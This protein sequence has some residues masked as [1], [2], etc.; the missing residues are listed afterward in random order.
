[1]KK[2]EGK[3]K[4]ALIV[5]GILIIS[6]INARAGTGF[7]VIEILEKYSEDGSSG[8]YFPEG[9]IGSALAV[10]TG[11]PLVY[12]VFFSQRY[13]SEGTVSLWFKITRT[14]HYDAQNLLSITDIGSISFYT[15]DGKS[16]TFNFPGGQ[17]VVSNDFC[18]SFHHLLF[19]WNSKNEA[20][21]IDG[22][23]VYE[24]KYTVNQIPLRD[25]SEALLTIH[26]A[27]VSLVDEIIILDRYTPEENLSIFSKNKVPW[28]VD[29]NTVFYAGFD[30][31][32]RAKGVIKQGDILRIAAYIGRVDATF[33]KGEVP[34][35]T[36]HILNTTGQNQNVVL[37]GMIKDIN[38]NIIM[39]KILSV[40]VPALDIMDVRFRMDRIKQNGLLWGYFTVLKGDVPVYKETIPFA[41]TLGLDAK[42]CKP[43]EIRTGFTAA[44]STNPPIYQK[45]GLIHY[46]GWD[47]L[48]PSPG[49]WY[50]ERL[51]L[52]VDSLIASGTVPVIMLSHPPSWYESRYKS[53]GYF[54]YYYP[55]TDDEE[56]MKYWKNYVRK[57]GE[58]YKGK[59]FDYEVFGEA[60]GRSDPHHY[61]R[62]VA[63]TS[64]VLRSIDPR[65]EVACNM[66]GY[67]DWAKIVAKETS[68]YADYYT[69]HPY[70]LVCGED[71]KVLGD[72]RYVE[73]YIKI[74]QDAGA[75]T[76][77]A[78]TEYGAYQPLTYG[79]H[80]DGYPM[81]KEEFDRFTSTS[82][83]PE[84]F[85]KRGRSAFTDWY[86][87]AFRVVRG[88]TINMVVGAKYALWWSSVG[89]GMISDLQFTR[90]TP[91]TA[92]VAYANVSGIIAGYVFL[93]KI[94]LGTEYLRAYLF[95]K[96]RQYIVVAFTDDNEKESDVYIEVGGQRLHVIDIYGN[97]VPYK[98]AGRML[99]LKLKP[100]IPLYVTEITDIPEENIPVLKIEN[101]EKYAYPGIECKVKVNI[102]NPLT[103]DI[104]GFVVL[105]LPEPFGKIVPQQIS[106]K[107]GEK[108]EMTF[109]IKIPM[110]ILN[111]QKMEVWFDTGT[112]EMG[113][114][115]L[116]DILTIRTSVVA[117]RV[118]KPVVIDGDLTEWGDVDKFP[119]VINDPEQVIAGIPYTKLYMMDQRFDWAG[120]K[121]L[122]ARIAVGYDN[123]NIYIA[124]RVWDNVV[125]NLTRKSPIYIYEGDSI[126]I[127]I[128]GRGA[129]DIGSN[130]FLG[131]VYH[132]KI[133]PRTGVDQP[134]FHHISK[135][136][137]DMEIP[138]LAYDS[139]L[140]PDGYTLEIKIPFAS[141]FPSIKP[142]P[143]QRMG[144]AFHLNDQD[145][146][147]F[148]GEVEGAKAKVTML[149][150]GEKGVSS[151]PSKFGILILGQ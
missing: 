38:K 19:T 1:M 80:P 139:R 115:I 16:R 132:I 78:N 151:D 107:S 99:K 73:S 33:R 94:D 28:K 110:G 5:I 74:L 113:T 111:N 126:E 60:Y 71:N 20:T 35:F 102:Y 112:K 29:I 146:K 136:K 79:V 44:R 75:K 32:I 127:F 54:G 144:L 83:M 96:G 68:G 120:D 88:H 46:D 42:R 122:S 131:N 128:D 56:A 53:K 37:K 125:M 98:K 13:P 41:K 55:D 52:K 10:F 66:G 93:R 14:P 67:H 147:K 133:A 69:I 142:V 137:R 106:I 148:S 108:K 58:R 77:I 31:S 104:K 47:T 87:T 59:V 103:S 26:S 21:Y 51:D 27:G 76:K 25:M 43:D 145:E 117:H 124:V 65:I 105:K 134:P 34:E 49:E 64:E 4:K 149:W 12:P 129:E 15:S 9:K 138:G 140:L 118:E 22:E 6:V 97:P 23:K 63:I 123:E 84:F 36:F 85:T 57:V 8:Y 130:L 50:F 92:S 109:K 135:P 40:K 119:V 95:K 70:N 121:D 141:A 7:K 2:G 11:N 39:E 90:H 81:T 91:S 116:T 72:E 89:G 45:W 30:G 101:M 150:G 18:D 48:E 143:G 86:T 3:G 24:K 100:L 82:E 17:K 61:G 62:L 114:V